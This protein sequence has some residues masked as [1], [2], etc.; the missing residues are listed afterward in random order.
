MLTSAWVEARSRVLA[1]SRATPNVFSVRK[2]LKQLIW[3]RVIS[4]VLLL[5]AFIV[6][7]APVRGTML[8]DYVGNPQQYKAN[9][10]LAERMSENTYSDVS[11]PCCGHWFASAKKST[12]YAWPDAES[13]PIQCPG[14][15]KTVYRVR[16]SVL[17]APHP[18]VTLSGNLEEYL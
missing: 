14:C 15:G 13:H 5:G 12:V 8:I 7:I 4:A 10:L 3:T 2:A 17:W 11:C 1:R 6:F 16:D 9:L 18:A